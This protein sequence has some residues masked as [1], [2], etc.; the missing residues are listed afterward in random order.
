[1]TR[2]N[3]GRFYGRLTPGGPLVGVPEA[4]GEPD[5]W[6]C[7]RVAD[8][9]GG[10]VPAGGAVAT[11]ATCAAPIVYNPQRRVTAPKHCMQCSDIQPLPIG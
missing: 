11:C 6:I 4:V 7:R 10:R 9:P 5:V 2:I 1:M 3:G 8:F